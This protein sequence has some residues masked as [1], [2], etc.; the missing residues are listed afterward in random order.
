LEGS[1][2]EEDDVNRNAEDDNDNEEDPFTALQRL[3]EKRQKS[4]GDKRDKVKRSNVLPRN[5]TAARREHCRSQ[6]QAYG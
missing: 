6:I 3:L 4:L 5:A 2:D 1:D